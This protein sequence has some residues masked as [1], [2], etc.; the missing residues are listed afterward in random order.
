MEAG[1]QLMVPLTSCVKLVTKLD[2][3]E[4]GYGYMAMFYE[5]CLFVSLITRE[6]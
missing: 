4:R 2:I 5:G 1:L 6:L 3:T